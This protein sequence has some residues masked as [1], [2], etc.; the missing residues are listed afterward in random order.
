MLSEHGM[1][2]ADHGSCSEIGAH[3]PLYLSACLNL[4]YMS[5]MLLKALPISLADDQELPRDKGVEGRW[6]CGGLCS[7]NG[8]VPGRDESYGERT[9]R[10][11]LHV[12]KDSPRGN[13]GH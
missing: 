5:P 12:D 13:K 3:L 1:V 6:Q 11:W 2:A 4:D 10:G 7:S 8:T 9:G